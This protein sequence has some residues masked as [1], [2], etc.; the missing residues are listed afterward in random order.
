MLRTLYKANGFRIPVLRNCDGLTGPGIGRQFVKETP[1][2]AL[3][4]TGRKT[5]PRRSG[6]SMKRRR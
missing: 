1:R 6:A 4:S 2:P 3:T 5:K